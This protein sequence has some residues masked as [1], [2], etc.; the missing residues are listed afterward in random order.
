MLYVL[1]Y[2]VRAETGNRES[3]VVSSNLLD[4]RRYYQV[5]LP[6]I[7]ANGPI[8]ACAIYEADAQEPQAAI[9]AVKLRN[10]RLVDGGGPSKTDDLGPSLYEAISRNWGAKGSAVPERGTSRC[11]RGSLKHE[12][13]VLKTLEIGQSKN[14]APTDC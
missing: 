1:R 2:L 9:E 12:P 14:V 10:A 8:L 7:G 3:F 6:R 13:E 11:E 4:A 5:A